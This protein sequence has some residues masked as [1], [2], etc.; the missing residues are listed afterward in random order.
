M[1]ATHGRSIFV[2]DN[3]TPLEEWSEKV[4]SEPDH[5]FPIKQA[6]IFLPDDRTWFGGS[7]EYYAQ[8]TEAGA[9]IVYWVKAK[10]DAAP[11][12]TI[13][14]S[15]GK[16][17]TTLAGEAAPGIH[18]VRWNMR[19]EVKSD[20]VFAERIE[21]FVKPGAYTVTLELGKDKNK[22]TQKQTLNIVGSVELSEVNLR[23]LS[24]PSLPADKPQAKER[25]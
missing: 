19:Q 23:E 9:E 16:T 10:G 15:A 13:A 5:L 3:I 18:R 24:D 4:Q 25:E 22:V 11:S 14:D 6:S 2:I 7:S 8:N 20:D 12:I 1:A 21:H 17:I